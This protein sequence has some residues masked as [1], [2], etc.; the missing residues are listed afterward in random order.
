MKNNILKGIIK[1]LVSLVIIALSYW[2]M[3]PPINWRSREFWTFLIWSVI[4]C[5]AI[6][7]FTQ[8]FDFIKANVGKK[9]KIDSK[10]HLNLNLQ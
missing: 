6:N 5:V 7:A 8:I 9:I 1:W 4:V 2:F 10:T 3:L